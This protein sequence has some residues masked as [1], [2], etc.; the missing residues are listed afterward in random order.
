MKV[1]AWLIDWFNPPSEKLP[2]GDDFRGGSIPNTAGQYSTHK[3]SQRKDFIMVFSS[4]GL[5]QD[6]AVS[7]VPHSASPHPSMRLPVLPIFGRLSQ[8]YEIAGN[9]WWIRVVSSDFCTKFAWHSG[10]GFSISVRPMP[11][12]MIVPWLIAWLDSIFSWLIDLMKHQSIDWLIWPPIFIWWLIGCLLSIRFIFIFS[13]FHVFIFTFS[14]FYFHI[15][16]FLFSHFHIFIFK[17]SNFHIF[18]L[19]FH[20][21]KFFF[22]YKNTKIN[23]CPMYR[24]GFT[25]LRGVDSGRKTFH[26]RRNYERK[27][28]FVRSGSAWCTERYS[29]RAPAATCVPKSPQYAGKSPPNQAN[30]QAGFLDKYA[31]EN[32]GIDF[33]DGPAAVIR[34]FGHGRVQSGPGIGRVR[35]EEED[36]NHERKF[37]PPI[38]FC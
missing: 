33:P 35:K 27:D 19:Y 2:H 21:F 23:F 4:I 36:E 30:C 12:H 5:A 1:Y 14:C 9:S 17:F 28:A 24:W 29:G 8:K 3:F 25:E 20:F 22:K 15:F 37:L 18:I 38:I 10:A 13:H 34:E 6:R 31:A 26:F 7:S 16:M 11:V 32:G